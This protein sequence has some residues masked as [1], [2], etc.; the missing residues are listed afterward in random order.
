MR[1]QSRATPTTLN[2]LAR[3]PR[4]NTPSANHHT[5]S[6]SSTLPCRGAW[7]PPAM[8]THNITAG[9]QQRQSSS[10]ATRW[11]ASHTSTARRKLVLRHTRRLPCA[12][13]RTSRAATHSADADL[14]GRLEQL[15]NAFGRELRAVVGHSPREA[16]AHAGRATG[17]TIVSRPCTWLGCDRPMQDVTGAAGMA[18]S[19]RVAPRGARGQ[20]DC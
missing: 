9:R 20:G 11:R 1:A 7:R 5:D 15:D 10:H 8:Q 16:E 4:H 18:Q 6:H 17:P 19:G 12:R 13:M 2:T 14:D 3:T